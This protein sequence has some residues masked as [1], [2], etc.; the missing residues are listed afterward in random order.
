MAFAGVWLSRAKPRFE[1]AETAG[2][3]K[4]DADL[5]EELLVKLMDRMLISPTHQVFDMDPKSLPM[6]DLPPGNVSSLYLMYLGYVRPSGQQPA[7]KSTFFCVA[8]SWKAALKFRHPSEH[9]MCLQCQTLKAA[10]R[11]ST[12]SFLQGI[13]GLLFFQMSFIQFPQYWV[14]KNSHFPWSMWQNQDFSEHASL[15]NQLLEHYHGQWLDRRVYW[16]ARDR[17]ILEGDLVCLNID[18]FDKSKLFLPKFPLNRTPKRTV[19]E[20]CHRLQASFI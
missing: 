11:A 17:A 8:K 19:Y 4:T 6:R 16:A 7:S 9:S 18:S 14:V 2:K 12:A 5:R 13:K 20:T 10:I 3:T 15:C 1:S